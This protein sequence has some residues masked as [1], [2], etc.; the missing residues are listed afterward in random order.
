[1]RFYRIEGYYRLLTE[2]GT[3]KHN[4]INHLLIA[5][6]VS[7]AIDLAEEEIDRLGEMFGVS[8]K[9]DSFTVSEAHF[10]HHEV[11]VKNLTKESVINMVKSKFSE[12]P[13]Y[14]IASTM[15]SSVKHTLFPP[16]E[17]SEK[18][19]EFD[20]HQEAIDYVLN[21]LEGHHKV[22]DHSNGVSVDIS[23]E[24]GK[25]E[26]IKFHWEYGI[27]DE[28]TVEMWGVDSLTLFLDEED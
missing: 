5:N 7:E 20:S 14:L 13:D 17:S 3:T 26:V 9:A 19:L 22:Y 12:T 10:P 6:D 8:A 4:Y 25:T 27:E 21:H 24:E 2:H 16:D 11:V 18:E 23:R 1:M 28:A 15:D